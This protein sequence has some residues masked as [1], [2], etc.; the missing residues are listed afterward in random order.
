LLDWLASDFLANGG[1]TKRLHKVILLSAAY[2]RASTHSAANARVDAGNLFLWRANRL[3][4]DAETLRDS[5]LTASGALNTK[6][7]GRPVVPV[8]GREEYITMWARNQWPEAMDPAEHDR[9]SVYLYVKRSFPLPMLTT[10]DAPDTSVSCARREATTVAPQALTLMNG[11]FMVRQS[12]RFAER[13]RAEEP[14]NPRAQ[15][16]RA[17]QIALGRAPREPEIEK[18]LAA[19][20][21][22]KLCLVLLNMNE[23][24]YVD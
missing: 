4:M 20:S 5:V 3:R 16:V 13:L 9:R 10:F 6:M 7:G 22:E 2:R 17:W 15:I 8:L 19:P 18:A 24:L 23:F 14:G 21:L 12:G 11:D 1:S